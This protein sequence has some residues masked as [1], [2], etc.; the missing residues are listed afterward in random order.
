M[1]REPLQISWD[2]ESAEKGG[3]PH[4][5]LKEVHEQPQAI[6]NVLRGRLDG[7]R[8]SLSEWSHLDFDR[9][10]RVMIVAC[11]SS[12]YAG[13]VGRLLIEKWAGLPVEVEVASEF[14]YRDPLVDD[15][16][17]V[18]LITLASICCRARTG[19][20]EAATQARLHR[21]PQRS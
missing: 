18:V 21:N 7:Q 12:Y 15:R 9:V 4:F 6:V 10:D 20:E 19:S 16:S 11:G 3:Y 5:Y 17:L 8:V 13:L 14:R 1:E 2:L